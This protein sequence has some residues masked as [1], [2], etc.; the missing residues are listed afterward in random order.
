MSQAY[1]IL[2][3]IESDESMFAVEITSDETVDQLKKEIKKKESDALA[4]IDTDTLELYH[5][6]IKMYGDDEKDKGGY[7]AQVREQMSK[8]QLPPLLCD[9]TRKLVEIFN[10]SPPEKTLHILVRHPRGRLLTNKSR[11]HWLTTIP[12]PPTTSET[13]TIN[14]ILED[15][16]DSFV[17][18]T[19]IRETVYGLKE[20]IK[21][22][23]SIALAGIDAYRLEL[24]HV[25]ILAHDPEDRDKDVDYVAKA[26][27][28]M[29]KPQLPP[30]LCDPSRKLVEVFNGPPPKDTLHIF[31][32][33]PGRF[34]SP[35]KSWV[36]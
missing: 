36:Y 30:K 11:V 28:E 29:S 33:R 16:N 18:N 32:R 23:V 6:A 2:C 34:S 12:C 25:N 21:K 19:T 8:P 14:C 7:V 24:Y 22:E 9:P 1:R 5:V 20:E 17:V 26:R 13:Y 3:F 27:E 15:G 35:T 4:G 31:V 10:G